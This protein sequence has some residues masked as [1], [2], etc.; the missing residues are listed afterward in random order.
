MAKKL[1]NSP[2]ANDAEIM[3]EV[4]SSYLESGNDKELLS[5]CHIT[6]AEKAI[7]SL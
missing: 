5:D 1:K 7:G 2:I 3:F 6:K 4:L